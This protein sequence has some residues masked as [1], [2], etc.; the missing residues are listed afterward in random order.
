[1]NAWEILG[2]E[3]DSGER[4]IKRAYALQLKTTRPEDDPAAFQTLREAYER[5]L[6]MAANGAAS[7]NAAPPSSPYQEDAIDPQAPVAIV[8]EEDAPPRMR[9]HLRDDAP[10]PAPPE[11][12]I[13]LRSGGGPAYSAAY[14]RHWGEPAIAELPE[15]EAQRLW[16]AFSRK[17]LRDTRA[18]IDE[19]VASGDLLDLQ[20]R[21]CFELCAL[22]HCARAECE[23]KFRQHMAEFFEWDLGNSSAQRAMPQEAREAMNRLDAYRSHCWL[24]SHHDNPVVSAL[25]ATSVPSSF[26]DTFDRD[27]TRSMQHWIATIRWG[28]RNMLHYKLNQQVFEA[29]EKAANERR[30]FK[31]TLKL[32]AYTG[33]VIALLATAIHYTSGQKFSMPVAL[34]ALALSQALAFFAVARWTQRPPAFLQSERFR[35]WQESFNIFTHHHRYRPQWQFGWMAAYC[36]GTMLMPLAQGSSVLG[37]L[38]GAF[39]LATVLA[40]VFANSTHFLPIAFLTH[41][42]FAIIL[43]LILQTNVFRDLSLLTNTFATFGALQI[44]FRGGGDLLTWLGC[45]ERKRTAGRMV[46]FI[47]AMALFLMCFSTT[48]AEFPFSLIMW[49]W[50]L[51]GFVFFRAVEETAGIAI[52]TLFLMSMVKVV[53]PDLRFQDN[54]IFIFGIIL[55]TLGIHAAINMHEA[56]RIEA[57]A[58]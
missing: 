56:P 20:V 27:F 55:L 43:G 35:A 10:P 50:V 33:L 4:A 9:R 51:A 16:E 8:A 57:Q 15:V 47:G 5:A 41:A 12:K 23:D 11:P 48:K 58:G 52:V 40:S 39:L 6:S 19:L 44:L 46:W 22:R 49:A 13:A 28:H 29:W 45:V 37:F 21:E 3:S 30:Y 18:C 38:L 31:Q 1:M 2:I 17:G 7:E 24:Y 14:E 53:V 42:A 36:A 26:R 32:S 34:I 25:L 54:L